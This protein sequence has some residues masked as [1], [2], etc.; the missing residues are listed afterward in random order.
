MGLNK[1]KQYDEIMLHVDV[2]V[3]CSGAFTMSLGY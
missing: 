2:G 1:V 3:W